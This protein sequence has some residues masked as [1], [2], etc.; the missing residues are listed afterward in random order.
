MIVN[1][2]V[3]QVVNKSQ[4]MVYGAKLISVKQLFYSAYITVYRN[5]YRTY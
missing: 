2:I 4:R 1:K 5:N 3:Q